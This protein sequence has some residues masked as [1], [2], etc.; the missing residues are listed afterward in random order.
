MMQLPTQPN[1][2]QTMM[3]LADPTRRA[4]LRRLLQGEARVTELADPFPISLNAVSKHI[5]V[6]ERANLV[7]RRV[8]GREHLL[9]FN[10]AP[11][12]EA[13][14]WIAEQQAAWTMRLDALDVMLDEELSAIG[15]R[16]SAIGSSDASESIAEGD[17]NSMR[18]AEHKVTITRVFDAPVGDVY[19]A[20]TEP[21]KMRSWMAQMVDADVRV[22][23]H[24]RN[25]LAGDDGQTYIHNGE[26]RVLEPGQRIVQSFYV[27]NEGPSPDYEEFLEITFR[28]LGPAQTELTF[29]DSW[30]GEGMDEEG[31]EAVKA[32]WNGWLDQLAKLF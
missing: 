9:S 13:A 11:L 12:H 6:L 19:A 8:V 25:E 20:W 26:Y 24:Y 29:T 30:N 14:A 23:G 16:L 27:G 5:R 7:R 15:Y 10:P 32:A 22:G 3:A 17:W 21:G 1:L 18:E 2:D 4:I 28:R 31:Q